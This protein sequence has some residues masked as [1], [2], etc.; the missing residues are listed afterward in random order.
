[1]TTSGALTLPISL[2]ELAMLTDSVIRGPI[3]N[4]M[5]IYL[6]ASS[7]ISGA[8]LFPISISDNTCLG[9]T[10]QTKKYGIN[11]DNPINTL[12]TNACCIP[13]LSFAPKNC[14]KKIPPAMVIVFT[15]TIKINRIWP[16]TLTPDMETSPSPETIKLSI[17]DTMF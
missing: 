2:N 15:K 4:I 3:K 16:A 9:K 14:V 17:S 7:R 5:R 6:T 11:A 13:A 10:R 8:W 12:N 1:M